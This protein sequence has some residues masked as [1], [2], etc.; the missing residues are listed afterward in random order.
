M[1]S[2]TVETMRSQI[3]RATLRLGSEI[4]RNLLHYRTVAICIGILKALV[5]RM[6]CRV[7]LKIIDFSE[8][9]PQWLS[10]DPHWYNH[11]QLP[12]SNAK[13]QNVDA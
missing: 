11:N 8:T 12:S 7:P 1:A 6:N 9:T 2:I 4:K 10:M 3:S 13:S 5:S